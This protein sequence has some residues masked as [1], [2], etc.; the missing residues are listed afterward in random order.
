MST[1]SGFWDR[2]AEKYAA[3]PVK[4]PEAYEHTL[5]R[6]RAY[7][8]PGDRVLEVGCGT[9]TTA[10]KLGPSVGAMT[11]TD[12]SDGMIEIARHKAEEQGAANVDFRCADVR[13]S[14]EEQGRHDAILA[15]NLLHLLRDPAAAI[16]RIH[17][18]LRPGGVFISKTVCLGGKGWL[19]WPMIAVMQLFGRA[20]HVGFLSIRT[21]EEMIAGAG[22][23]IVETGTFPAS[24]P[25]RFVVAGKL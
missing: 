14:T 15:F 23:E 22:F 10:L 17:G 5:E 8:S 4:D 3:Q 21:L 24:P 2:I 9:G 1:E 20:P 11:G 18:G 13:G 12:F 25:A 7:L 6:T 16:A 19:F